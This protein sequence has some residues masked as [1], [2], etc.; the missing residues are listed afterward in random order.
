[1]NQELKRNYRFAIFMFTLLMG[2]APVQMNAQNVTVKPSTGSMIASVPENISGGNTD[3]DTF[4][5]RGGF[6]TWRHNQLCL[7]MTASDAKTLTANGQLANPANN[8]YGRTSTNEI[9]LGRGATSDTKNCYMN[10]ALP[11]GYRFTGYEIVFSRN[12]S[13]FGENGYQNNANTSGTTLFGE[14]DESFEYK[15]DYTKSVTY[16]ANATID[17]G[18]TTITHEDETGMTNVLYFKLT[19]NNTGTGRMVIT[20]HSITLW[21]TPEEDYTPIMPQTTIET[22]VSAVDIPF[23]TGKVDYGSI[24]RRQYNGQTR[25]SYSSANVIDMSANMVLYEAESI[26]D[27]THFDGT[28][29]KVVEYK[30]GSIYNYQDYFKLGK[31]NEEQVYFLETPTYVTLPDANETKNPVGFRI[32]GAELEYQYGTALPASTVTKTHYYI[33]YTSGGTTYYLDET[34]HFV[35]GTRTEWALDDNNYVHCGDVY[36]TYTSTSSGIIIISY[37]HSLSTG[38]SSSSNLVQM[39]NNR[40][41]IYAPS[42]FLS[43]DYYYLQGTTSSTATPTFTTSTSNLASWVTETETTELPAFTPAPFK[44]HVYGKDGTLQETIEVNSSDDNGTIQLTGLNNDAIK[45]GVEGI[46]FIKGTLTMQALD[47]YID[48]MSVVCQDQDKPA[49]RMTQTFTANDFSVSGGEFYFYLPADCVGDDVK[50]TY[51]D[52]WSHY[53]DETYQGGSADHNSRFSFVKSAHYD[54]YTNDNIY[55]NVEEAKADMASVKERQIVETVGKAR[56]RFN[57]ADEMNSTGGTLTEYPFTQANYASAPNNGQ[58]YTMLYT[59]STSDQSQTAYVFTTDE[60]RYN[61]APTTA[62]QHRTYAY[63]EMIVHVQSS[64][65]TPKVEIKKIYDSSCYEENGAAVSKPFYGAVVTA[66]FGTDNEAGFASDLEVEQA[67]D[68]VIADGEDSYGNTDVPESANQILY[69]DMSQL[70]GFYVNDQHDMTINEY[71][72][73]KLAK[74]ALMFLPKGVTT[75]Y[76]NFA[77]MTDGNNFRAANNI[78]VTD[79]TPFFS[80]YDIQV[81]SNNY[82]TYKRLITAPTEKAVKYA[83]VMLPFTLNADNGLHTNDTD[84]GFQFNLRTMTAFSTVPTE[85]YDGYDYYGSFTLT[86]AT[87]AEANK[88]YMVEVVS[89]PENSEYSFIAAQKGSAIKATPVIE[90]NEKISKVEGETVAVSGTNTLTNYGTY[91][92]VTIP[93]ADNVFYFNRDKYVSSLNLTKYDYVY[94]QPFRAYF[95]FMGSSTSTSSRMM[96]M[97]NILYDVEKE[98]P[99]VIVSDDAGIVDGMKNVEE[100]GLSITSGD[101]FLIVTAQKDANVSVM[102]LNGMSILT[103]DMKAGEQRIVHV[104]TG[105]YMVNKTKV[106]IK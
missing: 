73:Q 100:K 26:K 1:M 96:R 7:T 56:F 4:F 37:S 86:E 63:Y 93:K 99:G 27:G 9:E 12:R 22:P 16:N 28:T 20:F 35:T 81:P 91:S 18:S 71:K 105:V 61:I 54:A 101:G 89:Q 78:I 68:A 58:F 70:A 62:V 39:Y 104:P 72:N 50:I 79:K 30:A 24:E 31:E 76:D 80:P 49:I 3:Y 29:G 6:A 2:I 33:T 21:F 106:Y 45:F 36:L 97:F 8:L 23:A 42:S 77:Y 88:P 102:G 43:S 94:V 44:L 85:T 103:T 95:D 41:R 48:R 69:V 11:K 34:G 13:D 67:I 14:T 10:F 83:T 92:G 53:A 46:G 47:P 84:D 32:V 66:P 15:T 98:E 55:N 64:T 65:Y 40:L 52:L 57:N 82:A 19:D 90:G 38:T 74:N 5:R 59:V 25:V 51:E 87:I 75:T 17:D 60:T